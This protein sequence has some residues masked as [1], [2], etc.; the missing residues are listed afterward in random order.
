MTSGVEE[1][2]PTQCTLISDVYF[3]RIWRQLVKNAW[4]RQR[5]QLANNIY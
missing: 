4:H 2:V 5:A 3:C 1:A